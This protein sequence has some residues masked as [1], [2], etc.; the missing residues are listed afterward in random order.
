MSLKKTESKEKV[1]GENLVVMSGILALKIK[2]KYT[3]ESPY[4]NNK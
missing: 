3:F 1:H 2:K 4:K